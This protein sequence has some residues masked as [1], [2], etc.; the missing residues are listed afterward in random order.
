MNFRSQEPEYVSFFEE[1]PAD[2]PEV[3]VEDAPPRGRSITENEFDNWDGETTRIIEPGDKVPDDDT[4]D[5]DDKP[6]DEPPAPPAVAVVPLKA[7]EV[8]VTV[9]DPGVFTP[10][11]YSFSVMVFDGEGKNGRPTKINSIEEWDSLLEGEP[12]LGSSSATLKAERAAT[13]MVSNSER[14]KTD[15]DT[16]KAN[17]DKAKEAADTEMAGTQR[18]IDEMSYLVSRGDLPPITAEQVNLNW[19][20]PAIAKQ[21][22]I[23]EQVELVAYMQNESAKRVA[24][25]LAPMTSLI[26]ALTSMKLDQRNKQA[27]TTKVKAGEARREAG[28]RV[29]GVQ[30]QP[31]SAAPKGISVGRG[32]SLKDLGRESW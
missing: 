11:D 20:D 19:K 9:P 26:D 22:G 17:F 7:P 5:D 31:A 16:K 21:P 32:G 2:E 13:R 30:P 14:D 4:N 12:N 1:L 6:S 25:G 10:T 24:A 29:A 3:P 23:K 8:P 27:S 28:A 15:Y 18:I